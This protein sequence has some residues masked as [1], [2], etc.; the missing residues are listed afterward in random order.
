MAA[1]KLH[2]RLE[3]TFKVRQEDFGSTEQRTKVTPMAELACCPG[4]L[5]KYQKG[6][7]G[8]ETGDSKSWEESAR[9]ES[10][11]AS[12][13]SQLLHTYV[14]VLFH[15]YC[16]AQFSVHR[17]KETP[18]GWK[19]NLLWSC[20]L[21][22]PIV[23]TKLRNLTSNLPSRLSTWEVDW[24]PRRAGPETN[25][26]SKGYSRLSLNKHTEQSLKFTGRSLWGHVC[27]TWACLWP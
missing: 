3:T 5:S 20:K 25:P 13:N 8:R 2:K 11:E 16:T 18:Q 12:Q 19:K 17:H 27:V 6:G 7:K 15:K 24:A 9:L 23:H 26:W 4:E 21:N 1:T 14:W 22:N 10:M